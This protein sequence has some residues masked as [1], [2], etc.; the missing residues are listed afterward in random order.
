VTKR[1]EIYRF[2]F[3][4]NCF[5]QIS[6]LVNYFL[7]LNQKKSFIE[8][9]NLKCSSKLSVVVFMKTGK[10]VLSIYVSLILFVIVFTILIIIGKALAY[11]DLN[12]M[13]LSTI[14]SDGPTQYTEMISVQIP[15]RLFRYT[16]N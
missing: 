12:N 9:I 4:S 11:S 1:V 3:D 7:M 14:N 2:S 8:P 13:L 5:A 15:A 16:K 6:M 10:P